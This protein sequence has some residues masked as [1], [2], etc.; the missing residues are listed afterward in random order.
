MET[1]VFEPSMLLAIL[2]EIG[3]V[4]LAATL[5]V[6]DLVWKDQRCGRLGL[7]TAFGI[8]VIAILS[9][10]FAR[11]AAEPQLIFG[12]M[13]RLDSASYVFRMIF[14][15]GAGLTALFAIKQESLCLHGEF[16][17]LMLISTLGLSLMAASADLIML[18]LSIE[19]ASI[20]LY[21]LAGFLIHDKKSVEAG[22]KYLLFGAMT[23]AIMLYGF[24]LMYGFTGTTA[25][26]QLAEG[27]VAGNLPLLPL[28][29]ASL[30]VLAGFGFKISAVPFH[31]WAPDVYEGAASPIAGFMSTVSKAAGFAV[32]LRVLLALYPGGVGNL[33]TVTIA[34]LSGVSMIIGNLL[35]LACLLYTSPSQ[36]DS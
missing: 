8:T 31:F 35:A 29:A 1:M 25:L 17:V 34:I 28:A 10:I 32:L 12:G 14:L 22:I 15:M 21:A 11:P 6:F 33:W 18:Y 13:L 26:Y 3:L 9:A 23:S 19:T 7:Y 36:R 2:P 24:S 27:F 20:P 30:M 4:V 5:L 16:Y